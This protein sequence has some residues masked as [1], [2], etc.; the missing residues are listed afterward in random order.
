[1]SEIFVLVDLDS[2]N[3]ES[4]LRCPSNF[5]NF[6]IVPYKWSAK[7]CFFF[8]KNVFWV[9]I[10][11][12]LFWDDAKFSK[13]YGKTSFSSKDIRLLFFAPEQ[14]SFVQILSRKM[15]HCQFFS[16]NL[17]VSTMPLSDSETS[18][19]LK[20]VFIPRTIFR[21]QIPYTRTCFK[22]TVSFYFFVLLK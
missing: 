16:K 3:P 17:I 9:N 2:P 1:M 19:M 5:T 11:L 18:Y 20:T 8:K 15:S 13:M 22:H 12:F 7:L 10:K 4:R 6:Q 21:G 14:K